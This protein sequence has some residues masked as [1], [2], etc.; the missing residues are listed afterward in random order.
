MNYNFFADKS[1]KIEILEYIFRETD[2]QLFDHSSSFGN[3]IKRYKTVDEITSNFDLE[4]GGQFA[5]SFQMWSP[6]HKS[7]PFFRKIN[8]KP[9][10]S[11]GYSFRY[12]TSGLGL[13]QLY[14]GG[15]EKGILNY[16]HIGHFNKKGALKN[17]AIVD[18]NDRVMDW[19]WKVIQSTS[20]KLKYHIHE[21]M[22]VKNIGSL[23]V[24]KGAE[25]LE[26]NGIVLSR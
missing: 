15:I 2:L 18:S 8:L 13:I 9:K 23:G 14:L 1:D 10:Y 17:E 20:R 21:K 16:S 11:N 5:V 26:T 3:K 6:K 19:D 22:T 12:S 25:E 24:L 7:K 4:N